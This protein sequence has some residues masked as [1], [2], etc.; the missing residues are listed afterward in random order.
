MVFFYK[1]CP[2]S[3]ILNTPLN[4]SNEFSSI[5]QCSICLLLWHV[6]GV[7]GALCLAKLL[8]RVGFTNVGCA[9]EPAVYM[10][11]DLHVDI[12]CNVSS[13]AQ[14]EK[15]WKMK[16]TLAS[17]SASLSRDSATFERSR[18]HSSLACMDSMFW[19]VAPVRNSWIYTI[20]YKYTFK[21]LNWPTTWWWWR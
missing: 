4:M 8:I 13:K 10:T 6:A 14:D 1:G 3:E 19:R 17:R 2:P 7:D 11:A 16:V 21:W 5:W 20:C 12:N 15:R 18:L 9:G